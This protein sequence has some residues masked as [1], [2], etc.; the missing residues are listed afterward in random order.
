MPPLRPATA[1]PEH[2]ILWPRRA[3]LKCWRARP[4]L[5][6]A[7]AST[8]FGSACQGAGGGPGV[9]RLP[10][11]VDPASPNA[12]ALAGF[13]WLLH[14]IMAV[15][16]TGVFAALLYIA[17]RFR[18]QPGREAR[19]IFGNTR[20]EIGWTAAPA[21]V[22]LGA[23]LLSLWLMTIVDAP[24]SAAGAAGEGAGALHVIATGRQWWWEYQLPEYGVVTANE[25]HLPLGQPVRLEL[26]AD[27]VIHAWWVPQ[28]SG[29]RDMI[30]GIVNVL[31]FTPQQ[32][33]VFGGA[34]AEFCGI[35]HAWMR[36][37][38][39]V[40]SPQEFQSWVEQQAR[41]AAAPQSPEAQRGEQ[42][43][44]AVGCAACHAVN[45]RIQ[46]AAEAGPN[47][48][49]LASRATIGAGVLENTPENLARWL[50]NPQEVKPGNAM[51]STPLTP[52]EVAAL[53]AYLGELR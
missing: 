45:G 11:I 16:F 52:D 46:P 44:T 37:R 23:F 28:L 15:V 31:G 21:L 39:V 50:R 38:V 18:A 7:V 40:E 20:L 22:V 36:L 8:L 3:W 53:T 14:A 27:D 4:L 34:C 6:G 1:R 26:R 32:A 49:H 47:L 17:W 5:L 41:P 35:Q 19:L 42:L 24:P 9:P 51:P 25:I 13:T 30:P 43:F 48:T 33:G 2:P 10:S 29:K 12:A